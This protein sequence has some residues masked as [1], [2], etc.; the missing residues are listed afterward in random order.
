MAGFQKVQLIEKSGK[1][2]KSQIR[3]VL[4]ARGNLKFTYFDS[5]IKFASRCFFSSYHKLLEFRKISDGLVLKYKSLYSGILLQMMSLKQS[6][7]V[8]RPS[9]YRLFLFSIKRWTFYIHLLCARYQD[10]SNEQDNFSLTYSRP[11]SWISS[12]I[13]PFPRHPCQIWLAYQSFKYPLPLMPWPCFWF[14]AMLNS[15]FL[16]SPHPFLTPRWLFFLTE[17]FLFKAELLTNELLFF[18]ASPQLFY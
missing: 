10:V 13:S 7:H 3:G 11:G 6:V 16:K 4:N 8:G 17:L 18:M 14:V 2:S 1:I 12:A 9:R 5:C 15:D